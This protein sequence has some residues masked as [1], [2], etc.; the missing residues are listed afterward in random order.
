M[1]D[2]GGFGGTQ[3]A[4]VNGLNENGEVVGGSY[5]PGD[6]QIH[7]FLWDGKKLIDLTAPPF[8]GPGPGE[9]SWI[10][11]AGEVV[12]TASLPTACPGG[13]G[14]ITHAFL[15]REG[16][17]TDLGSFSATPN[18]EAVFINSKSQVVGMSFSCDTFTASAFLWE[19]GSIID[20]NTLIPPDSEFQLVWAG[21]IADNG[22]IG[23]FGNLANGDTH[24]VLLLP[25]DENHPNLEGCDYSVVDASA[26]LNVVP[27][28]APVSQAAPHQSR[29]ESPGEFNPVLRFGR[30]PGPRNRVFLPQTP[31]PI[32]NSQP[33][34]PTSEVKCPGGVAESNSADQ[35]VDSSSLFLRGDCI[36]NSGKLTGSCVTRVGVGPSG[37]E[38]SSGRCQR[39]ATAKS[40]GVLECCGL[41]G[42]VKFTVD[43][44]T[45][46]SP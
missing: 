27:P 36:E 30:H 43:L 44:A 14:D 9:A 37:C 39:G 16:A 1:K 24:A 8:G 17:I 22:E 46:C 29:S 11:E 33:E 40:P 34:A 3:A 4:S 12:G 21:Y 19:Q 41:I 13:K 25:C 18:S 31:T 45:G 38:V 6:V 26:M 32:S 5:L 23:A 20:L 35:V 10:N 7:P 28:S 2:L 15:W 42:C